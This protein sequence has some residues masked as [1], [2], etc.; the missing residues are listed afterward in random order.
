MIELLTV[1]VTSVPTMIEYETIHYEYEGSPED[2]EV[3]DVERKY[4]YAIDVP[5]IFFIDWVRFLVHMKESN[6]E[7][8]YYYSSSLIT[9]DSKYSY[10]WQYF[11][12]VEKNKFYKYGNNNG[13]YAYFLA[14]GFD[15]YVVLHIPANQTI[16]SL[17]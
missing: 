11:D 3:A 17:S 15:M 8:R 9:Y 6:I 10:S 5:V 2:G 1:A 4:K 12:C 13:T 16:R 14:E 7:H